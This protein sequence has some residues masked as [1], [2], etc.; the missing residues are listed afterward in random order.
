MLTKK[1]ITLF[2]SDI[3]LIK[4]SPTGNRVATASNKG[5]VIR[6]FLT[7]SGK[8]WEELRVGY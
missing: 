5:T 3:C 6:I 8:L 2:I 4:L 1:V 7:A